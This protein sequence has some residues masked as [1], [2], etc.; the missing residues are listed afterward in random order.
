MSDIAPDAWNLVRRLRC[1]KFVQ[2]VSRGGLVHRALVVDRYEQGI[3]GGDHVV[4][5]FVIEDSRP[6]CAR[7][8]SLP[9]KEPVVGVVTHHVIGTL[10]EHPAIGR[11]RRRG[12]LVPVDHL[13]G[14]GIS[15]PEYS[16]ATLDPKIFTGRGIRRVAI[17]VGPIAGTWQLASLQCG[18][19]HIVSEKLLQLGLHGIHTNLGQANCHLLTRQPD[20]FGSRGI[21]VSETTRLAK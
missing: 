4:R 7:I 10:D 5:L 19:Q 20:L 2:H 1:L 3:V 11:E 9:E 8:V 13:G 6:Q 16:Q 21:R 17:L 12:A 18:N 15:V 14:T